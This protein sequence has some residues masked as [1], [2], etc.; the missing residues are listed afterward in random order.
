V[1]CRVGL[2]EGVPGRVGV[3]VGVRG[4]RERA[5]V[6]RVGGSEG[7]GRRVVPAGAHA[8]QAGSGVGVAGLRHRAVDGRGAPRRVRR[9]PGEGGGSHGRGERGRHVTVLVG[10]D[11]VARDEN[12]VM[13]PASGCVAVKN[14]RNPAEERFVGTPGRFN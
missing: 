2:G 5:A 10:Q 3:R 7:T 8:D 11:L 1:P 6:H 4:N 13:T 9:P 12:L 14:P